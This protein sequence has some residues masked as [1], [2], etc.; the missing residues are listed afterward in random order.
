MSWAPPL[1]ICVL[2]LEWDSECPPCR[3][4]EGQ[5]VHEVPEVLGAADRQQPSLSA[6]PHRSPVTGLP[7]S[8]RAYPS[9][10]ESWSTWTT[11]SFSTIATTS[12]SCWTW[13]SWTARSR[14]SLRS[15]E[16]CAPPSPLGPLGTGSRRGASW[17]AVPRRTHPL[18]LPKEEARESLPR[19]SRPGRD[20][21]GVL[22]GTPL[23][24][25]DLLS[26][27]PATPARQSGHLDDVPS[28][29]LPPKDSSLPPISGRLH[30]P[31]GCGPYVP[32]LT[33]RFAPFSILPPSSDQ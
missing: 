25:L 21:G 18:L 9:L 26:E 33:R 15:C 2:P 24:C 13:G 1:G 4:H 29:L 19:V 7:P 20:L 10:P 14:S 11:T 17:D 32:K 6:S 3:C 30:S 16:A 23:S 22:I 12:P 8:D 27:P 5:K 28:G 31:G